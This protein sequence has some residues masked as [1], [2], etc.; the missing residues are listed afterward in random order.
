MRRIRIGLERTNYEQSR[1]S[2]YFFNIMCS[3]EYFK[4]FDIFNQ[5]TANTRVRLSLYLLDY[6]YNL[7]RS[8]SGKMA[9]ICSN[10]TNLMYSIGQGKTYL[11]FPD[12]RALFAGMEQ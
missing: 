11:V 1:K 9:H 10:F 12:G 2:W 4:A 7:Q 8:L 6:R 3:L 5:L